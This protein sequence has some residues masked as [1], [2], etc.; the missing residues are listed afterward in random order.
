M[1]DFETIFAQEKADLDIKINNLSNYR[2]TDEYLRLTHYVQALLTK[3]LDI[4]MQYS[5]ILQDRIDD[6]NR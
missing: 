1:T 5:R 2:C 3:Q 4:M 6:F